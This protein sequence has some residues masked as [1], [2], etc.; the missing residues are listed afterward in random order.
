[1]HPNLDPDF[2]TALLAPPTALD[3]KYTRGVVGFVTGSEQ[4]PGAALLGI[5]AAYELGIGM[6]CY[7]GPKEVADLVMAKRPETI[8]GLEKAQVLVLGSGIADDETGTQQSNLQLAA[9]SGLPLVIDAGAL[10]LVDLDRITAPA[11]LTPHA[12]EAER[13]FARLGHTRNRRDIEGNPSASAWE[14]AEV[15]GCVVLLKGSISVLALSGFDPIESG[16]GSS[17]LATAGTGD[18]LAG[19]IGA[20]GAKYLAHKKDPSALTRQTLRDIGLLATQLHSE[21]AELAAA[22]GEFGASAVAAAISEA[23]V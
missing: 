15:T 20:L 10:A 7:L 22:R 18:V 14:L 2:A 19:M 9:R 6:A 16:P 1:M 11:I 5:E 12:G 21:A 23:V 17:H 3:N 13:L 8:L 4:Y